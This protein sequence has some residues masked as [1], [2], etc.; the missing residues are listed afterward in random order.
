MNHILQFAGTSKAGLDMLT[1][2]MGFEL[3]PHKVTQSLL[4]SL[5]TSNFHCLCNTLPLPSISCS[6][7]TRLYFL[8]RHWL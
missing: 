3:G 6:G 2:M 1:K 4:G 7:V 8:L 5:A